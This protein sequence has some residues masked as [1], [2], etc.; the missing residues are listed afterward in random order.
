MAISKITLNGVTQM[1]V[2]DKTVTPGTMY[3]GITAL[4]NDGTDI[5]G[6]LPVNDIAGDVVVNGSHTYNGPGYEQITFTYTDKTIYTNQAVGTVVPL[7]LVTSP[8][9]FC[10]V[11]DC[12]PGDIFKITGTGGWSPRLWAFIDGENKM[13]SSAGNGATATDLILT[14]PANSAKLII[15]NQNGSDS[16]RAGSE[17]YTTSYSPVSMTTIGVCATNNVNTHI[18]VAVQVNGTWTNLQA[19]SDNR[20][21]LINIPANVSGQLRLIYNGAS[22]ISLNFLVT[23][24]IN[25]AG[26][27]VINSSYA[28][29]GGDSQQ[30]VYTNTDKCIVTNLAIGE[31]VNLTPQTAANYYCVVLNCAPGDIFKITGTGGW[32]PRLW[33]FVDFENKLIS[34]ADNGATATDLMLTAPANAAKLILNNQNNNQS[35]HLGYESYITEYYPTSGDVLGVSITNNTSV[36]VDVSLCVNGTWAT[37]ETIADNRYHLL[38]IPA[39][40]SDRLIFTYKGST[41]KTLQFFV[42]EM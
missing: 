37:V 10:V 30:I 12:V 29:K 20:Y 5:V 21:Y 9:Y 13:L 17:D 19:I 4:K 15:N 1:D 36:S 26:E 23:E 11:L 38:G 22:S 31:T 33:A 18:D 32:T 35:Y 16:Y 39:N 14:A 28:Y 7:T 8:G 40:T 24:L 27:I 3:Y 2:T 42:V 41:S 6:N 34:V 25:A